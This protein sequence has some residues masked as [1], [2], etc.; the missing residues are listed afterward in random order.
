MNDMRVSDERRAG[1]ARRS[2][3][4]VLAETHRGGDVLRRFGRDREELLG[5]GAD[6]QVGMF[7][8]RVVFRL[9]STRVRSLR[10]GK[11]EA[12]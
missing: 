9:P 8:T 7:T 1:D 11:A 12:T 4:Q 3:P 2:Q 5:A 10:P 6:R